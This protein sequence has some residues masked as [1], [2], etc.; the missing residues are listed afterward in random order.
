MHINIMIDIYFFYLGILRDINSDIY[1]KYYHNILSTVHK[2]VSFSL[3][4]NTLC[5]MGVTAYSSTPR[6]ECTLSK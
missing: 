1:F 3:D 4:N 6:H 2:M 5:I